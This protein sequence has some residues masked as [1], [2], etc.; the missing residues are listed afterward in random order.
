MDTDAS[1]SGPRGEGGYASTAGQ[2]VSL[3]A[4]ALGERWAAV[5]KQLGLTALAR[6]LAMQAECI[7]VDESSQPTVWRFRV[8]RESLRQT[9]LKD[10]L[11]SALAAYFGAPVLLELEPGIATDSPALRDTQEAQARQRR[12][13][14]IILEDPMVKELLTQFKTARIV[15]GSIKP[16]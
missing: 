14:Q 10:K 6:E 4:T 12:A 2:S 7:Q 3:Q 11:Q 1:E 16:H 13:E 15:P 9:A 8:E 5:V